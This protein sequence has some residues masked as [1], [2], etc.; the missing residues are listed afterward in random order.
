MCQARSL[1]KFEAVLEQHKHQLSEE[2]SAQFAIRVF[3]FLGL[4]F[5]VLGLGF[6]CFWVWGFWLLGV[7]GNLGLFPVLGDADLGI[8]NPSP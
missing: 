3:V 4:G 5:G 2:L 7:S 8:L 1:K 6:W